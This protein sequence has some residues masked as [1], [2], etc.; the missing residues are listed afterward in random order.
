MYKILTFDLDNKD[1]NYDIKKNTK[2]IVSVTREC[3][4]HN[5]TA[6]FK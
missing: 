3:V 5:Q 1:D 2:M 6:I 4:M